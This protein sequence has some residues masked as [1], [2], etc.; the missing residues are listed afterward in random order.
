MRYALCLMVIAMIGCGGAPA[1]HPDD[2]VSATWTPG[3]DA[4]L[5]GSTEEK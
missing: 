1:R 3:D 2:D 5:E 4:P